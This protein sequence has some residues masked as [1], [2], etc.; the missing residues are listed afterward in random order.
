MP[1]YLEGMQIKEVNFGNIRLSFSDKAIQQLQAN[2]NAKGYS[3]WE[4]KKRREPG[5]HG[6]THYMTVN[7]FVP[8]ASAAEQKKKDQLA[9]ADL[10]NPQDDLPF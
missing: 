1:I 7:E 9:L 5:T 4:L 2:K 8:D 3:N 10:N 6:D